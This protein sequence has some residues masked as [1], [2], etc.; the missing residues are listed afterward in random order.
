MFKDVVANRHVS[1]TDAIKYGILF[2][3]SRALVTSIKCP[4]E[5]VKERMQVEGSISQY[6][7]KE[8]RWY[9]HVQLIIQQDG[10]RGQ[11]SGLHANIMRDLPMACLMMSGNDFYTHLLRSG[12]PYG[13][14]TKYFA[15]ERKNV[16]HGKRQ[17]HTVSAGAGALSGLTATL[18]TQPLDVAKTVMQ[19]QS[20]SRLQPGSPQPKYHGQFH[21]MQVLIAERG[22]SFLYTGT[23]TRAIHVTLGGAVYLMIYRHTQKF[24]VQQFPSFL[25]PSACPVRERRRNG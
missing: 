14:G 9:Q 15:E 10:I 22:F 6:I 2:C 21:C 13:F 8:R 23:I 1:K 5:I 24:F 20:L 17:P 25:L 11:Y 7:L 4:F 16:S 18:L 19:T 3:G 12:T